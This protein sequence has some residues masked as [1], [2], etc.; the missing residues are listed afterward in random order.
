M[1]EIDNSRFFRGMR[2]AGGLA[3][4]PMSRDDL[5]RLLEALDREFTEESTEVWRR[6]WEAEASRDGAYGWLVLS[7]MFFLAVGL[8]HGVLS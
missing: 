7:W 4:G 1:P 2:G 8:F 3:T 6:C 5:L